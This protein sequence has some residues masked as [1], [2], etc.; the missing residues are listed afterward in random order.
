MHTKLLGLVVALGFTAVACS[1]ADPGGHDLGSPDAGRG[2]RKAPDG[3]TAPTPRPDAAP[4][5]QADAAPTPP[6][7]TPDAAPARTFEAASPLQASLVEGDAHEVRVRLVAGSAPIPDTIRFE[8]M[9]NARGAV[10]GASAPIDS[11]GV[12]RVTLRAGLATSFEVRARTSMGELLT[13]RYAVAPRFDATGAYDLESAID[14]GDGFVSTLGPGLGTLTDLIDSPNDPATFLIDRLLLEINQPALS[15]ALGFLRPG[16][17]SALNEQLLRLA[18]NLLGNLRRV[19]M[20]L[21]RVARE[22]RFGSTMMVAEVATLEPVHELTMTHTITTVMFTTSAGMRVSFPITMAGVTPPAAVGVGGRIENPALTGGRAEDPSKLLIDLHAID[23]PL[24]PV[25]RLAIDRV[26]LPELF[27]GAT[28]LGG[29][30]QSQVSC[31]DVGAWLNTN[32]GFGGVATWQSFCDSALQAVGTIL[33]NELSAWLTGA[34]GALRVSGN[35]VVNDANADRFIDTLT[36][37]NWNG[38]FNTP[39][40]NVALQGAPKS[41]FVGARHR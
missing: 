23:Y 41:A 36:A 35:A 19:G 21:G 9:G 25:V 34:S 28:S 4:A 31:M 30:L 32:V 8:T 24:E 11:T 16:I 26:I 1:D 20:E 2:G 6:T 37:G 15:T 18:P 13:F 5:P 12:A 38:S 14:L 40:Q 33:E 3:G 27:P 22:M 17:D 39:S 7:P 10:V 29:I